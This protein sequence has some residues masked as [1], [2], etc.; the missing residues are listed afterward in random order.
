MARV[1]VDMRMA[2]DSR[3]F[4]GL[5]ETYDAERPQ[6]DALREHVL[7][8]AGAEPTGFATDRVTE[9]WIDFAYCGH[10]F[11][12]NNQHGEWWFFVSDPACPDDVMGEVLDHFEGLLD[13][14]AREAGR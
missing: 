12:I 6:W 2:D 3:Y 1:L 5:P 10:A 9:A 4:G 11:S 13:P 14:A 7:L 8:L